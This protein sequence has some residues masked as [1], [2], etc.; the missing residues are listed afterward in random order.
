MKEGLNACLRRQSPGP[1][2][3]A[4]PAPNA[5]LVII[6]AHIAA[7]RGRDEREDGSACSEFSDPPIRSIIPIPD[8]RRRQIR[9][10]PPTDARGRIPANR[11]PS[12][13]RTYATDPSDSRV[14][15]RRLH[16]RSIVGPILG[17]ATDPIPQQPTRA[18]AGPARSALAHSGTALRPPYPPSKLLNEE[19]A[20]LNLRLTIDAARPRHRRRVR[21]AA[22]TRS[23]STPPGGTCSRT[24]ATSR[25]AR[26]AGRLPPRSRSRCAFSSTAERPSGG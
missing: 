26:T 22:P 9:S 6:A 1:S 4:D 7:H 17:H 2:P 25:R 21:S 20:A 23:S 18:A 10:Q 19:E 11:K 3:G 13:D 15:R 14:D 24:G 16:D 5:M 12:D 8:R